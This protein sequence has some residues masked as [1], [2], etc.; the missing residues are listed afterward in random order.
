MAGVISVRTG[1]YRLGLVASVGYVIS[2]IFADMWQLYTP[3]WRFY[4]DFIPLGL[5]N[6]ASLNSLYLAAIASVPGESRA[7]VTGITSLSRTLGQIVGVSIAGA[8]LASQ[9]RGFPDAWT[10]PLGPLPLEAILAY[11]HACRVLFR[12]VIGVSVLA[13]IATLSVPSHELQD[14]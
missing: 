10:A 13:C 1:S 11:A 12:W 6:G 14:R 4:V 8:V 2:P 7:T 5:A 3:G 9:T